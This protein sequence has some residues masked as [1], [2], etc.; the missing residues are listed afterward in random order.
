VGEQSSV[1]PLAILDAARA[2]SYSRMRPDSAARKLTRRSGLAQREG[3][4]DDGFRFAGSMKFGAIA[5]K[6]GYGKSLGKRTHM[7]D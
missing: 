1:E 2:S 6:E 3:L 4:E 5:W 7:Q